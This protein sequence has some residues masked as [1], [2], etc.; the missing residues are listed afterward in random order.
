MTVVGKLVAWLAEGDRAERTFQERPELTPALVRN[1]AFVERIKLV[2]PE[3]LR[4]LLKKGKERFRDDAAMQAAIENSERG[5]AI[6]TAEGGW[7]GEEAERLRAQEELGEHLLQAAKAWRIKKVRALLEKGA[8][9][10]VQSAALGWTAL[11]EAALYGRTET[12]KL[13]LEHGADP[14]LPDR[15]GRT[16]LMMAATSGQTEI[17]RLLLE[18]GA[19]P[20]R[21]DR[22]ASTAL[23]DAAWRAHRK[24]VQ[25][26]LE[27]GADPNMQDSGQETA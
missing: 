12:A 21:V 7:G 20:N 19:D 6:F 13:L 22:D 26:L 2:K 27:C 4:E 18:N 8:N 16:P 15:R 5:L 17:V 9:P 11:M 1:P 25:L 24:G 10:N 23:M 14:N 3:F